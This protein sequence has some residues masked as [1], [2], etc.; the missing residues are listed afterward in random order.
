[1]IDWG[2]DKYSVKN[3]VGKMAKTFGS[4]TEAQ[5]SELLRLTEAAYEGHEKTKKNRKND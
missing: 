5:I 2:I 1:M 4:L 3:C